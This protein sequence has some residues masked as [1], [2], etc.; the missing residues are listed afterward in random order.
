MSPVSEISARRV[1]QDMDA[2][3]A[4]LNKVLTLE[5]VKRAISHP[6][7]ASRSSPQEHVHPFVG[8]LQGTQLSASLT[9]RH[10]A[11]QQCRCQHAI[12][13]LKQ[14][15]YVV[16]A[17]NCRLDAEHAHLPLEHQASGFA[18]LPL[19]QKLTILRRPG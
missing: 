9:T 1:E 16:H 12:T 6:D 3:L 8:L 7:Q 15:V 4:L 13:L 19:L 2:L 11:E 10:I 14:N 18:G 17:A 5:R